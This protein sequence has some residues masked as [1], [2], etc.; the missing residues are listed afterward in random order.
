MSA[1]LILLLSVLIVVKT[2]LNL[3]S[4]VH[5]WYLK[6]YRLDRMF[7]HLR[8]AQGK[9]IYWPAFRRP[10]VTPKT[11]A[12][13]FTCVMTLVT[14]FFLIP[15]SFLI[16]FL[17]IYILALPVTFLWVTILAIPTFLYHEHKIWRATQKL[18]RSKLF[19]IGITGSYGKTTTKEYIASILSNNYK[20]LKTVG[21]KNSPI[22]IAE[23]ALEELSSDDEIFVV[24]MAA[25][26]K[27]EIAR[28]SQIV[29]PEIGIVTAINEQH[30]DLFGSLETTKQAKYELIQG[31]RGMQ[32]AIFNADNVHTR[33]MAS[34]AHRDGR[35]VWSISTKGNR[36]PEAEEHFVASSIKA[37]PNKISF[38]VEHKKDKHLLTVNVLG[39]H[40]AL[41]IIA[42][43][44]GAVAA[45][46]DFKDALSAA[47]K[48]EPF[49]ETMQPVSGPNGSTLINDT[50]N[51][52]PDAALAALDYL[53]LLEGKK[54]L[55][56]TP[57]IELGTYASSAHERVGEAAAKICDGIL[58]T[59][60]NFNDAFLRGVHRVNS[61]KLVLT[62]SPSD[63]ADHIR[64]RVQK[65]DTVLFKGK[66]A[67][68]V[69]SLLT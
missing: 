53:S 67:K 3:V 68:R 38:T 16:R 37:Y 15:T 55:V 46:M 54:V 34:W 1:L 35:H 24:E 2:I 42:A 11:V 33:E 52:N 50:F 51:N 7:I 58:L 4:Y 45:G 20:V 29:Q 60:S 22:A 10:P 57:M 5:L 13:F 44:A 62:L 48:L 26:K 25:Y 63:T 23:K 21:S 41:N 28:M 36:L 69:L 65:G 47:E 32:I 66:E 6:E 18:R 8:T 30:Q 64:Q 9:K 31:L 61:K 49:T 40:Q 43:V 19:S 59:N 12:L 14:F 56:F 39:T 27:G 17:I